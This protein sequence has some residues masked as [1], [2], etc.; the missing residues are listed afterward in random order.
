V[1]GRPRGVYPSLSLSRV[2][3][4]GGVRQGEKTWLDR[5]N[6]ERRFRG[7]PR[8]GDVNAKPKTLSQLEALLVPCEPN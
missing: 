1:P 3:L 8:F 6:T 7:K 4:G 2:G 5:L